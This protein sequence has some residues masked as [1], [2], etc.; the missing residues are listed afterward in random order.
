MCGCLLLENGRAKAMKTIAT[1]TVCVLAA[2]VASV[3]FDAPAEAKKFK[4]AKVSKNIGKSV[5][6]TARKAGKEISRSA[7]WGADAIWI[8]T[9]LGAGTAALTQNCKYYYRRYQDTRDPKWRSKYN[10]CI[11]H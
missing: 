7:R 8:G 10:A 4:P 9:G 6:K 1:V 3:S 2:L 11:R 5:G